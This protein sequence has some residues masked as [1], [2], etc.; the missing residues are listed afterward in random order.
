M[1]VSS[2]GRRSPWRS[3]GGGVRVGYTVTL[4][5]GGDGVR[6]YVC[7]PPHPLPWSVWGRGYFSVGGG[8]ENLSGEGVYIFPPPPKYGFYGPGAG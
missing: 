4:R 2:R 7:P 6:D 3:W 1:G 5:M 8:G